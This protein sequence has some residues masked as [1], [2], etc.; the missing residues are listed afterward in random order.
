MA[1]IDPRKRKV[2]A[3]IITRL[4]HGLS[5]EDAKTEIVKDRKS[6]V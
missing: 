2:V 3:D 5:V 4:H 1:Q 6:V